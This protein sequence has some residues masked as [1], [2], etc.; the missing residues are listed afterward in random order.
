MACALYTGL[1]LAHWR[2]KRCQLDVALGERMV[3]WMLAGGLLGAHFFSVL[4]Y[5]PEKVASDPWLLLRV[6][7]DISS[8]GGMLGGLAG[9]AVYLWFRLP[10]REA[11]RRWAY[12]D[13]IGFVFPF[14]LAI[15]R[16]G[17]SLAHDHPGTITHFPLAFSL[18]SEAARNYISDVY[19]GAGRALP[20][21]AVLSTMGFNDLGWYEFLYLSLI[22]LP[23]LLVLDKRKH[24]PGFNLLTSSMLY[25][26]VRFAFDFLRVSD[27]R[28]AGLTP[29]QWTAIVAATALPFLWQ[30]MRSRASAPATNEPG[31]EATI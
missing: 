4:L 3:W 26:P 20:G 19:Y 30:S 25:L 15:G 29:G 23:V 1:S 31:V 13:T 7:E 8:F 18:Q 10:E 12:L 14:A 27:A 28:Y 2:F 11:P 24:A 21:N 22:M 9:A 5:F 16:V 17:C 6:W